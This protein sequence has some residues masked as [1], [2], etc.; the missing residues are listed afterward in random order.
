MPEIPDVVLGE[1]IDPDDWGNPIRDR[2][3]Q[4]Y[5]DAA[6]RD[7]LSPAPAAGDLAL[8]LT[9]TLTEYLQVRKNGL[10]NP[11]IVN[12]NGV[13]TTA[14]LWRGFSGT[15]AD[16]GYGFS[17][18]AGIGLYRISDGLLGFASG[19]ARVLSVSGNQVTVGDG[20][21][22]AAAIMPMNPGVAN[23]AFA[24]AGD[25]G[26][27]MFRN[28]PGDLGWAISTNVRMRLINDRLVPRDVS[29]AMFLGD[30]GNRWNTVYS[31][32]PDNISSLA[33]LKDNLRPF[34]DSG[35]FVDAM[36]PEI[37]ERDGRT[38]A[39]FTVET[40]AEAG[41]VDGWSPADGE[42]LMYTELLAPVFA[43][44]RSLRARV[45]ELE[46]AAA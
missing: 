46:A 31:V 1:I 40:A 21:T 22:P 34:P 41:D 6:E 24:F 7:A 23:P 44:L 14:A 37:W 38:G 33:A 27:G 19:G 2:T 42:G 45:A 13:V 25:T 39:G 9:G 16:P 26:T 29:G 28:A 32:N 15:G 17:A 11:I 10:W 36:V 12:D 3:V 20:S 5:Q 43:E 8:L 4:R 35:R 30:S 18:E